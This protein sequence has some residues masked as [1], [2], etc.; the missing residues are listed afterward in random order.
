MKERVGEGTKSMREITIERVRE[1]MK[2]RGE[3]MKKV[4]EARKIDR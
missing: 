1:V 3:R 4:R 2:T